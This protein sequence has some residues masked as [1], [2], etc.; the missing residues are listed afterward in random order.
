VDIS[1]AVSTPTGLITPIV[2]DAQ[3]KGLAEISG[4][5]QELASRA[6]EGKL[7]PEEYQ[8]GTFTISNLGMFG[9]KNF[10][11]IINPPQSCIL[12]VCLSVRLLLLNLALATRGLASDTLVYLLLRLGAAR[13]ALFPT[14][15][16]A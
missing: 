4:N 13:R 12:A 11:A 5:V 14:A 3:Y 1:V 7:L 9:V 8:G 16:A 15:T 6:R 2:T 10:T